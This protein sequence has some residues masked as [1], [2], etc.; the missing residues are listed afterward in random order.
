[1]S[2]SLFEDHFRFPIEEVSDRATK[3]KLS[4][5]T[6]QFTFEA[7]EGAGADGASSQDRRCAALRAE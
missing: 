3:D 4:R 2:D 6:N 7:Q 5:M 1:M